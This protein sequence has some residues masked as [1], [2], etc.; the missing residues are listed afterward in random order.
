MI[1]RSFHDL[2]D[3]E[4]D[5]RTP[6]WRSK[7][8]ILARDKA[9]FSVHETTLYAGT[10]NEFWYANHIE[11]VMIIEGE[12]TITDLGTGETHELR[13]GTT[14]LLDEHDKHVV[15]PRT[16]IRTICVF[17]PPVTGR[18]VHDENGV[19]PLLTEDD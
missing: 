3:T 15:R 12:G 10:E 7:R 16:E 17:N 6:S 4:F 5:V 8:I 18:E 1:V 2:D 13:P 14:Y 9:G 19:Y 11:A